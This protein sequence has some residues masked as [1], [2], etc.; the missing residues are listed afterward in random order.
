MGHLIA[1]SRSEN[2][3]NFEAKQPA[4]LVQGTNSFHQASH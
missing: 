1:F 4:G 3:C 2:G